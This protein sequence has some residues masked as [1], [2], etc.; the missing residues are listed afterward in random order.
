MRALPYLAIVLYG[1]TSLVYL[2]YLFNRSDRL[3]RYGRY[4]LLVVLAVHFATIGSYCVKGLHPLTGIST[5]LNMIAFMLT[6]GYLVVGMK[7]RLPVAGA[8]V[9][10]LSLA[11]VIA[12]QLTPQG[13]P[14]GAVPHVLGKLHLTLVA[15]GV[16][17]LA[18]ATAVAVVY[19][20]QET[21]LRHNQLAALDRKAPALTTLDTLGLRLIL[22][23]FP[24]FLLAVLTGVFW[25][26]KLGGGFRVEHALSAAILLIYLVLLLSRL[27]IGLRGRR[28]AIMTLAGFATTALVLGIYLARRLLA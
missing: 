6:T 25:S 1:L 3:R 18:L 13:P 24:L 20:R 9:V 14:L 26:I 8:V 10:P 28:A 22:V 27:T 4:L 16:T 19:L 7:W 15:M 11:L 17:A 5:L 21:S 2:A 23:G 12:G